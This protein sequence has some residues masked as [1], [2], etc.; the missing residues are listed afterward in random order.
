MNAPIEF[1]AGRLKETAIDIARR[2]KETLLRLKTAIRCRDW[3]LADQL[4]R[5]LVP[6]EESNSTVARFDRRA[7]RRR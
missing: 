4:A 6:D 3:E 5:E 7:S 2:R 1:P